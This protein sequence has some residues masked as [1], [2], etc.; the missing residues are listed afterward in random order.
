MEH[1]VNWGLPLALDLFLAAMGAGAFMFAVAIDFADTRKN[2]TV[3]TIGALVAPWPA[4]IGVLLLVV[5]LGNPQRFWEMVLKRH[6]GGALTLQS[7]YLQFN[8]GSVMSYGT[9]L[10]VFFITISLVYIVAALLAYPFKWGE[11]L[12]KIVG[13][14]GLPFALGVTLYTG[15]LLSGTANVLW[16]TWLLPI[17]FV[18]SAMVTGIASIVLIL[19]ALRVLGWVE[20]EGAQIPKMEKFNSQLII[21]QLAVVVLFVLFKIT[22]VPML[23]IIGLGYGLLWWIGIVGLGLVVPMVWGLKGDAKAPQNSL[24][25]AALV[26]LGGFF[27]RYVILMAG[28]TVV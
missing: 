17:L 26:L 16:N 13:V 3:S 15:V 20:E 21:L 4:I 19:A 18:I 14:A 10:L 24:G 8:P 9:W 7:P 2:R 23:S 27:L 5:D 12:K 1:H 28:Q 6:A 22:T 25:V 11:V